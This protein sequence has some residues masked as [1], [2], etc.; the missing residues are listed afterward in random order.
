M[1][2]GITGGI[3]SG[4]SYITKLLS[5]QLGV[6]KLSVDEIVAYIM[7]PGGSGIFKIKENFGESFVTEDGALN[8][9]KMR[10]LIFNNKDAKTLLENITNPI[11]SK[12]FESSIKKLKEISS[13][14][15]V[16]VPLL[17]EAKFFQEKVDFIISVS[18]ERETQVKRVRER[19]KFEDELINKIIDSQATNEQRV[20]IADFVI[21]NNDKDD[22]VGQLNQIQDIVKQ[23]LSAAK[24]QSK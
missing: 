12:E 4:K 9:L 16:E 6:P 10:E 15:V 2:I 14:I 23:N 8:R 20:S 18:C 3:G 1:I 24:F 13:V 19:N 7:G 22:L 5:D 11:I 17:Y 21:F